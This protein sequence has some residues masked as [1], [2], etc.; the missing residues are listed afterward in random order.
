VGFEIVLVL[1]G[2]GLEPLV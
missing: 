2:P 1:V